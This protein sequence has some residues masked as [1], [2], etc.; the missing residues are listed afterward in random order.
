M[1]IR[2]PIRHRALLLASSLVASLALAQSSTF[3]PGQMA[4]TLGAQ[5]NQQGAQAPQKVQSN[6]SY[7]YPP[8]YSANPPAAA[9]YNSGT[10]LQS[11]GQQAV[12]NAP[13]TD[14]SKVV[15]NQATSGAQFAIAPNDPM[16][17]QGQTISAQATALGQT[18]QGCQ[19]LVVGQPNSQTYTTKTCN[20]TEVSATQNCSD[21]LIATCPTNAA[22][23]A[24]TVDS[25][26]DDM[27][28]SYTYPTLTVGHV[29]DSTSTNYWNGWCTIFDRTTT[30]T[31]NDVSQVDQFLMTFASFD[32]YM[33][34]EINGHLV[35][36]GPYGGDMV[37]VVNGAVQYD[38]SGK[39]GPCEL[40]TD[41]QQHTNIDVKPML[42]T[43]V[44]TIH[45]IVEVAGTGHGYMEFTATQYPDCSPYDQ[46]QQTCGSV[47]SVAGCVLESSV[48]TDGPSTHTVNGIPQTRDCWNY[49]QTYLCQSPQQQ[50]LA[51][52]NN[53]LTQGC[54]QT[55]STCA[56]HDAQGNCS[57]YQQSYRC[58]A[59]SATP[60]AVSLCGNQ[61]Y[62]PNGDCTADVS[63]A[64]AQPSN[65]TQLAQ[66][67]SWLQAA[68]QAA[69]D[70]T[71]NN[72]TI[73]FFGGQSMQ[74]SEAA[75]GFADCCA[76]SG[77][78]SGAGLGQ[79]STEEQTLGQ[80]K[81]AGDNHVVGTYSTGTSVTKVTYEVDCV[82]TS[83]LA[84]IIQEQGRQQLGISWGS[85]QSP[86]CAALTQAQLESI[87]FSKID[88][89]EFYA[90]AEAQANA[91]MAT[92]P[93]NA[94][95][96]Q[97]LQQQLQYMIQHPGVTNGSSNGS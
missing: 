87:D 89:S 78:G 95:I 2:M 21:Q 85:A 72:G 34:V 48:C 24:L 80:A 69:T 35:F 54:Q 46:W 4:R 25:I 38:S 32:D 17:T 16:L 42:V 94:A 29:A 56:S 31:I 7:Y 57:Q 11:Q 74:C 19:S 79:C 36:N 67:S 10:A 96:Q 76:A 20:V 73:E 63:N 68:Q 61:L 93:T 23:I 86:N 40:S 81:E 12:A 84:R 97:Q 64:S 37:A 22:P 6:P 90:Q 83:M 92:I 88:F 45:T 82:F 58:P 65:I 66:A 18:Y 62:C 43:G 51:A 77:W 27:G 1:K 5:G 59:T 53:L 14:P 47:P 28:W 71:N 30:F 44:N 52:C 13:A 55:G 15:V 41:W 50:S 9:Y 60:N 3:D 75:A 39:T 70:N 33:N 49:A 91:A 8:G 26:S